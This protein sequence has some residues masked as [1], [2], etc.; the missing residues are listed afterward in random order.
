M[1]GEVRVSQN[2]VVV[3]P[4]AKSLVLC[5]GVGFLRV[6]NDGL[7]EEVLERDGDAV[8]FLVSFRIRGALVDLS[9]ILIER[10]RPISRSALRSEVERTLRRSLRAL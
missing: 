10:Q 5:R 4:L 7:V 2:H 6:V 8:H 3:K 9:H 1:F